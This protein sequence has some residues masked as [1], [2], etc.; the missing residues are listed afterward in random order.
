[1]EPPEEWPAEAL[2][3]LDSWMA[4]HQLDFNEEIV[5]RNDPKKLI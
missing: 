5:G 1:M 3:K 2:E 4:D